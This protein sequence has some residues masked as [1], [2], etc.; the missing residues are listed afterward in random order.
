[1]RRANDV[2]K[3]WGWYA[4]KSIYFVDHGIPNFF[5]KRGRPIALN[6]YEIQH[7]IRPLAMDIK[8]NIKYEKTTI[9]SSEERKSRQAANII[10]KELGGLRPIYRS[11]LDRYIEE[12][13]FGDIMN[14]IPMH[15]NQI[16][17]FGIHNIESLLNFLD[18]RFD[19]KLID[20][21]EI[22]VDK[23]EY[24]YEIRKLNVTNKCLTQIKLSLAH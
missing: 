22:L 17:M 9:I 10:G 16:V 20:N 2:N 18:E 1:M 14:L 11:P 13:A 7:I 3:L 6:D 23:N 8:H 21:I 12:K 15:K 4:M 19:S 24:N 5:D